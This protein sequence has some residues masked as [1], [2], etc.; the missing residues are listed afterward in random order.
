[1]LLQKSTIQRTMDIAADTSIIEEVLGLPS[2]G[3][4]TSFRTGVTNNDL[5]F[6]FLSKS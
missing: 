6:F 2:F 1:M 3:F 5:S 4:V